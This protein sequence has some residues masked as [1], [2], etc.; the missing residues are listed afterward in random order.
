MYL[1]WTRYT[2]YLDIDLYMDFIGPEYAHGYESGYD[3]D[4]FGYISWYEPSY[5]PLHDYESG[6]EPGYLHEYIPDYEPAYPY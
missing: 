5:V 1:V 6:Y 3:L 2:L 4:T